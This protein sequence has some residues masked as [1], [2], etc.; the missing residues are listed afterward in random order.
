VATQSVSLLGAAVAPSFGAGEMLVLFISISMF[1]CA[2]FIYLALIP[3]IVR[4]L[5]FLPLSPV[6]FTA[7]Y[8]ISMGAMAIS[9]LTGAVL[10]SSS[11]RSLLIQELSP[12]LLGMTVFFWAGAT[13][14]IPLLIAL[15]AWRHLRKHVPIVYE[16]TYW[17]AVF[18]IGMYA[19]CTYALSD[20][21]HLPGL[22][23]VANLVAYVAV[24]LWVILFAG[25]AHHLAAA[26]R[27]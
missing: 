10:L 14:W 18:P 22:S 16:V 21:V 9:A 27:K 11:A 7:D 23:V 20:L 17:S 3:L 26:I 5:E 15:Q 1:M 25:L 6:Q 2:C 8:W 13:W 24:S 4:R 12:V 19:A